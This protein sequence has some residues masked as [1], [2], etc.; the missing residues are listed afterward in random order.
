MASAMDAG[1][2]KLSNEIIYE[3]AAP[4]SD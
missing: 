1:E 4:T 2:G 3:F